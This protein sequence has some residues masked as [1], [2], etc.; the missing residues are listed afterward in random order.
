MMTQFTEAYILY[1]ASKSYLIIEQFNISIKMSLQLVLKGQTDSTGL[2]N[3]TFTDIWI[4]QP[5]W[6]NEEL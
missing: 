6:V 1:L 3:S 2:G 4:T 5:Q